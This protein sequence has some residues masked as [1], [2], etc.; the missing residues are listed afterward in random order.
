[1]LCGVINLW[2]AS[3]AQEELNIGLKEK[4]VISI[5][6][7]AYT[8]RQYSSFTINQKGV[9]EL[10]TQRLWIKA[11]M[12]T[13]NNSDWVLSP[14]ESFSAKNGT[15]WE[16]LTGEVMGKPKKNHKVG[17]SGASKL[18]WPASLPAIST[19]GSTFSRL[20]ACILGN[21]RH[22]PKL[23]SHLAAVSRW[24]SDLPCNTNPALLLLGHFFFFFTRQQMVKHIHT[25]SLI[26]M[27]QHP[28]ESFRLLSQLF[29]FLAPN[30]Y[31]S[32]TSFFT[33]QGC[34]WKWLLFRTY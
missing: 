13:V 31:S 24:T 3:L 9:R 4:T 32:D 6:F 17:L 11:K 22:P 12:H 34:T 14:G 26:L 19:L 23:M 21:I 16:T 25:R 18:I 28:E 20:P 27:L 15:V 5:F 7:L 2:F 1:M 10:W 29:L 30:F 33:A 8:L